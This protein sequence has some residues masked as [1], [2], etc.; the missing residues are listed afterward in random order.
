MM[1]FALLALGHL[2]VISFCFLV[3]IADKHLCGFTH[4]FCQEE[5]TR[6]SEACVVGLAIPGSGLFFFRSSTPR[7]VGRVS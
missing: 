1:V 3:L 2:E 6:P 4:K 7:V 5:L